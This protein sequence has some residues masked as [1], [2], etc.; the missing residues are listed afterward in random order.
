MSREEKIRFAR[1]QGV[2]IGIDVAKRKHFAQFIDKE[3]SNLD[4]GLSFSNNREGFRELERRF[5]AF[6]NLD[7]NILF[8]FEPCGDYWK[9]LAYYLKEK[10]YPVVLVN[11][12]H[13]KRTK[14]VIDNSQNKTDPKD[15]YLIANLCKQ[16]KYS[17]PILPEGVYA[18]L[19]EASFLLSES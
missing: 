3:G 8:G 19:R 11:P 17:S 13:L 16:G 1:R 14:E 18:E 7:H 4:K 6:P 2:F 9:P 5:S 12:Y 15:A 10:G